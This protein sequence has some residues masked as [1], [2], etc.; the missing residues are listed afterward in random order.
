[1]IK[2]RFSEGENIQIDI[3]K[4]LKILQETIKK[5]QNISEEN[6]NA[7]F[8]NY[9]KKLRELLSEVKIDETRVYQEVAI[10]AE[11][12]DITEEI[13]RLN[14]HFKLFQ[15]YYQDL[16]RFTLRHNL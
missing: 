4:R 1:M 14:S 11:K 3:I 2:I 12:K 5:I 9:K 8:E 15:M 7:H 6:S 13:V 16:Y 10:L